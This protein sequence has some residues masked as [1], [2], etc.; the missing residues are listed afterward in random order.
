MT[1][2]LEVSLAWLFKNAKGRDDKSFF[3]TPAFADF[4][5]KQEITVTA[6]DIGPVNSVLG[7]EY[8]SDGIGKFPSLR[9]EAP[10]QI[11]DQVKE[12]LLVSEDPDVPLPTP[13]CHGIY[14]GIPP[15]RTIVEAADFEVEDPNKA[16]LKGGFHYGRSRNGRVYLPPRPLMNHGPHRY[17]FEVIALKEPLDPSLL[18][19]TTTREQIAGAIVGKI[20]A[21][22]MWTGVAERKWR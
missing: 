16:L 6:P 10:P 18:N 5:G 1:A 19:A 3:K 12:W 2:L 17:F 9:W 14:T 21:W 13:I 15:T 4:E 22:G 11:A 20:L 7:V 8:T